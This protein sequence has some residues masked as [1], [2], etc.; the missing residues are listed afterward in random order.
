M[1]ARRESL[2]A[3]PIV[4]LLAGAAGLVIAA[5]A[6]LPSPAEIARPNTTPYDRSNVRTSTPPMFSF[7]IHAAPFVPLGST[8]TILGEPRNAEQESNLHEAGVALLPGRRVLPAAQWGAF[9]PDYESQAEYVLILGPKPKV[10]PGRL[11]GVLETGSV[12]RRGE[13]SAQSPAPTQFQDP[14]AHPR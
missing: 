8:A 7:L 5:L 13:P 2:A 3:A 1:S 9:S 14:Q 6:R 11:V 12:W 4:L 10:P